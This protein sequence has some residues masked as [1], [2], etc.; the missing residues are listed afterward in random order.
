MSSVTNSSS[1]LNLANYVSEQNVRD[2]TVSNTLLQGATAKKITETETPAAMTPD[3][4]NEAINTLNQV[5]VI[6]ERNLSFSV[7]DISGRSVIKLRDKQTDEVIKQIPSEELLKVA[8][9]VKRLQE[10]MGQ[11]I[12]LLVDNKV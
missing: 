6:K 10:Q 2:A 5:P 8:Q 9:D 12:G 11:S 4:L 7:D 1:V 3:N